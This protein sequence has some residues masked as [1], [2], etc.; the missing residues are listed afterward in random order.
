MRQEFLATMLGVHRPSVS[1]AANALKKAGLIRYER[2]MVT[3]LD[4]KGLG[5]GC[6]E[7]YELIANHF[8]RALNQ[9]MRR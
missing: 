8:E 5:D 1:I 2:G 7:C 4:G 6:C 9:S 3:V